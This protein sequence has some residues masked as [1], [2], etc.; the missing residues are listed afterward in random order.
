MLCNV[1]ASLGGEKEERVGVC[2]QICTGVVGVAYQAGT[3]ISAEVQD[4]NKLT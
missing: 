3:D 4:A 1:G 2:G